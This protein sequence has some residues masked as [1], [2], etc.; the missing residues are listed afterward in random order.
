MNN[1]TLAGLFVTSIS[2]TGCTVGQNDFNCSAGDENAL[3]ASSRTIYEATNGEL[4][5][6]DR[7]TYVR[8][9]DKQQ[10]TL[11]ELKEIRNSEISIPTISSEISGRVGQ[12]NY[13]PF[14]FSY[15]G[16]VLR[17]NVRVFRVW[18]APFVDT[19]DNLHLSSMVYTDIESRSW[20][21]G[22]VDPNQPITKKN[23][24]QL[25]DVDFVVDKPV[26]NETDKQRDYDIPEPE[27][28]KL[29]QLS[30]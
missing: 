1:I 7:I 28:Q 27:K 14:S 24:Y 16:E 23:A 12:S 6:N 5:T 8:D 4:K 13:A 26:V 17:K 30:N 15:D 10:V 21:L 25:K 3:C 2:I 18:I 9:G 22:T 29:Q 20:Q 19:K 11:K